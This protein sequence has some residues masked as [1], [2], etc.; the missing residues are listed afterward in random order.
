MISG[1]QKC[2]NRQLGA[3]NWSSHAYK[4]FHTELVITDMTVGNWKSAKSCSECGIPNYTNYT[5]YTNLFST[6][7]TCFRS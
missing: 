3:V 1:M 6:V 5:N 7:L 2:F 4:W